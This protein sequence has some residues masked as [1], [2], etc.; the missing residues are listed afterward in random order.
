MAIDFPPRIMARIPD[1]VAYI[2]SKLRYRYTNTS[3]QKALG[4]T[5]KELLDK[6]VIDVLPDQA[7]SIAVPRMREALSGKEVGFELKIDVPDSARRWLYARY[8]PDFDD[9]GAV[10][11]FS[12]ILSDVTARKEAEDELRRVKSLCDELP[13]LLVH[14]DAQERYLYVNRA[15]AATYGRT[16]EET[17]GLRVRDFVPAEVY[18]QIGPRIRQLLDGK[19]VEFDVLVPRAGGSRAWMSVQGI[20]EFA[21]SAVVGFFVNISDISKHKELEQLRGEFAVGMVRA[22]EA[23]RRSLAQELHD[24]IAQELAALAVISNMLERGSRSETTETMSVRLHQGLQRA[25]KEIRRLSY[26]LHPLELC[27]R[28]LL[29]AIEEFLNRTRQ[30]H[31]GVDIDLDSTG[32][33]NDLSAGPDV[34]IAIYRI[35][36]EAVSNA[37]RHANPSRIQLRM[38]LDNGH[39]AGKVTDNGVGFDLE[40]KFSG[41]GLASMR[42]RATLLGGSLKI[43]SGDAGT[44]VDFTIP[45]HPLAEDS[46]SEPRD[47]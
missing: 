31:E 23:E 34:D 21:G 44:S 27:E 14:C 42:Q 37:L 40:S 24:G 19:P 47:S 7:L 6:S 45:M 8:I 9:D 4:R 28:G 26:G 2:D 10:I 38:E 3:Y 39:L 20:P 5:E 43:G 12:A 29:G 18:E 22:Q 15:Y 1:L 36:Q 46:P 17:L 32:I 30:A 11:G 16:R 25:V 33:V 35:V 13:N 41:I